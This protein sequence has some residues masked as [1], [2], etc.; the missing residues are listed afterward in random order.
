MA[1]LL[2]FL[3]LFAA[4][5]TAWSQAQFTERSIAAG[6]SFTYEEMLLMGGGAA[7]FDFDNDGDEDLYVVGGGRHDVL[8]ENDGTGN[9]TDVSEEFR[10]LFYRYRPEPIF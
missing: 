1:R 6:L 10:L 5:Q 8:F 3:L 2:P 7:A 4:I 9:F